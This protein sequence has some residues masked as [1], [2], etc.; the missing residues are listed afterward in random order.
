[1]QV[2]CYYDYT[3]A[4]SHR[5]FQWLTRLERAL[6]DLTVQWRTFSLKEANRDADTASPFDDPDIS[7]VPVLALALAHA[8]RGTG[9][10]RYHA[11][12][13]E[14]MQER[15]LQEQDLL[16]AAAEAGV[17]VDS[18]GRERRRW[19]H[20]V[21]TTHADATSRWSVFGTPT[22]IL[23][24]DTAAFLKLGEVP[25]REHDEEVWRALCVLARCHPELLEIKRP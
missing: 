6:P 19:L 4:Y 8:A 13:F 15:R 24:G 18:F 21:A 16:A 7:S 1:M 14:A 9:F 17:D 3:C 20:E 23:D 2:T 11:H 5:A 22:L 25:A 10:A 12:V